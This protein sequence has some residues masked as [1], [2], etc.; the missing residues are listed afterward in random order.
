MYT[1]FEGSLFNLC[2]LRVDTISFVIVTS[3]IESSNQVTHFVGLNCL[4]LL[5]GCTAMV[6][7]LLLHTYAKDFYGRREISDQKESEYKI[8]FFPLT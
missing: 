5:K 6:Y 7:K 8:L 3:C 2:S 1:T 4:S